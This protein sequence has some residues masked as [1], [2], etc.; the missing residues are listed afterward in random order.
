MWSMS[1]PCP[2]LKSKTPVHGLVSIAKREGM[3][4]T[5]RGVSAI[6]VGAVPAHAMY[7]TIYERL[8][9]WL[10]GGIPGHQQ[11]FAYGKNFG[12]SELE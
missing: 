1:H 12:K 7:F 2:E 10:T 3:A 4:R 5:M 11:T 9:H 6:A 8:K